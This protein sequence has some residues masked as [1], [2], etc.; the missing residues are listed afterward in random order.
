[1]KYSIIVVLMLGFL[2]QNVSAQN[3]PSTLYDTDA[4]VFTSSTTPDPLNGIFPIGG[5]GI[6][7]G[8]FTVCNHPGIQ[9][10]ARISERFVGPIMPENNS[11]DYIS[12]VGQNNND[13]LALWNIEGHIDFGFAYGGGVLPDTLADVSL[14]VT[15]DCSPFTDVIEGP[16]L[17]LNVIPGNA[18]LIQFSQNIGFSFLCANF[19][20]GFDPDADGM[21]T[22]SIN[23][24]QAG[25][26]INS[27][28]INAI[29][30]S[31]VAAATFSANGMIESQAEG[32]RF[33]DGTVQATAA[34]STP[35]YVFPDT[36]MNTE[37]SVGIGNLAFAACDA[38]DQI[39]SGGAR[40]HS[41][42]IGIDRMHKTCPANAAGACQDGGGTNFVTWAA[43]CDTGIAIAYAICLDTSP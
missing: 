31:P 23:V 21:Y 39:I 26:I 16:Q 9:V 6:G 17:P 10:A 42:F 27:V 5:S 12:P 15:V 1:M 40:C 35:P 43:Q 32:F 36:Y 41:G 25:T 7:N 11:G 22:L 37:T 4:S 13:G 18:V 14:S 28:E 19:G 29:V 34:T 30:G 8:N 3:C 38:G 24:V 2:A 33:P 20:D